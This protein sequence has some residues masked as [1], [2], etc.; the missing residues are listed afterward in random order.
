MPR[1]KTCNSKAEHD[2]HYHEVDVVTACDGKATCG[3]MIH[4]PHTFIK[5]EMCACYGVCRCA[6]VSYPH[7]PKRHPDGKRVAPQI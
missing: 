7:S 3:E 1:E 5:K 2:M 4:P 6:Y